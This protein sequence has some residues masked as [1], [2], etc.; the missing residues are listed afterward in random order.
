MKLNQIA[1]SFALA[2]SVLASG[3]AFSAGPTNAEFYPFAEIMS[4]T[5]IDKNKDGLISKREFTDMM[6][7]A[8][9]MN[10]R[11]MGVNGDTMTDAQFREILM[12]L[13][14]GG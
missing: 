3:T 11:K 9:E 5:M 7:M 13:K 4:M 8:W 1:G 12:Y 6:S 10:A 14:A 2:A